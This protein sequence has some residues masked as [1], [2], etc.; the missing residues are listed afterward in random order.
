MT[1]NKYRNTR[2][3][4]DTLID[5]QIRNLVLRL[6]SIYDEIKNK[7]IT[8]YGG[9]TGTC[10]LLENSIVTDLPLTVV[11]SGHKHDAAQLPASVSAT[12]NTL[13]RRDSSGSIYGS[14]STYGNTGFKLSDGRDVST[15]FSSAASA[16]I[17]V[18]HSARGSGNRLTD[19]WL[20]KFGVELRI[21]TTWATDCNYD[22]WY[23]CEC[24]D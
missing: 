16:D 24:C 4:V 13:V 22:R 7:K 23:Q 1:A 20:E 18:S 10:D 12:P 5:P 21:V 9:T 14:G 11:P 19:I 15:L 6:E 17:L 2:E 3:L 8:I